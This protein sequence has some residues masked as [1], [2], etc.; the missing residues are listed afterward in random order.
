MATR[1]TSAAWSRTFTATCSR[2]ACSC[3]RP[4]RKDSANGKLRLLYEAFP[5]A[6][7]VE[8]AG[9]AATDGRSRIL[10]LKPTA[11]HD[12]TPLVIGS[13]RRSTEVTALMSADPEL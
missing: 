3:T 10:D 5:L 7:I 1:G 4:R 13:R 11:L 8:R 9:G 12:R 2:A 6:Y